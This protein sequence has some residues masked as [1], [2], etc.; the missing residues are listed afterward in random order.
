MPRPIPSWLYP[1]ISQERQLLHPRDDA[2][3]QAAMDEWDGNYQSLRDLA[4]DTPIAGVRARCS[5]LMLVPSFSDFPFALREPASF[6]G[7]YSAVSPVTDSF[8]DR[9]PWWRYP[10]FFADQNL[11]LPRFLA[12]VVIA[13]QRHIS[14]NPA[15]DPAIRLNLG[16]G[17]NEHAVSLLE[18]LLPDDLATA[19]FNSCD[20]QLAGK[21]I[22]WPPGRRFF[23]LF[24]ELLKRPGTVTHWGGRAD[25]VM[26]QWVRANPAL[27]LDYADAVNNAEMWC[28]S[29]PL[30][31]FASQISLILE[32]RG[33]ISPIFALSIWR[34]LRED[35]SE[36]ALGA[37]RSVLLG[38][39]ANLNLSGWQLFMIQKLRSDRRLWGDQEV[40]S[41]LCRLERAFAERYRRRVWLDLMRQPL[42]RIFAFKHVPN[43]W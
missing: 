4:Y 2:A 27:T 24:E 23:A 8:A 29:Y 19:L 26:S 18:V 20:L 13:A 22:L 35:H 25:A 11:Q 6:V 37:L 16:A 7:W 14:C 34:R 30:G 5:L 21:S 32:L 43:S 31:L 28:T 12:R 40:T 38:P 41:A 17:L 3:W 42:A 33:R 15:I 10:H 39:R 1:V 9:L 36:L